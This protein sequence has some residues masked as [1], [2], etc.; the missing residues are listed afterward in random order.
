MG[1][2]VHVGGAA[3]HVYADAVKTDESARRYVA[4]GR[5]LNMSTTSPHLE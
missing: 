3:S 1:F 5:S 4:I 2:F